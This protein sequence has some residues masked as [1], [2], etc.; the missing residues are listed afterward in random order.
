MKFKPMKTIFPIIILFGLLLF[1]CAT[2]KPTMEQM[3]KADYGSSISQD[4]AQSKAEN[5]F[6]TY[7]KDPYSAVYKWGNVFQGYITKG[8]LDGGGVLYGFIL[9]VNV[10]AKNGFGGYTGSKLYRFV[11]YNGEIKTV[12]GETETSAGNL[13]MK[14]Y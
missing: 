4:L 5:F 11:F 8:L 9:E 7:L 1:S 6:N 13:M 2:A 10:N 14:V 12:Y 3:A